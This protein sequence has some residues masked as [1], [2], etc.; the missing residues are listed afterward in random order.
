MRN[1][2][3]TNITLPALTPVAGAHYSTTPCIPSTISLNTIHPLAKSLALSDYLAHLSTSI[4]R[5]PQNNTPPLLSSPP[6]LPA[7]FNPETISPSDMIALLHDNAAH[8]LL[9]SI[10]PIIILSGNASSCAPLIDNSQGPDNRTNRVILTISCSSD[11]P[12]P[13]SNLSIPTLLFS[14]PNL[15]PDN[16]VLKLLD[17]LPIRSLELFLLI[18]IVD[19]NPT[20]IPALTQ[21]VVPSLIALSVSAPFLGI[22]PATLADSMNDFDHLYVI[23][24]YLK[25]SVSQHV[26]AYSLVS[27]SPLPTT[28]LLSPIPSGLWPDTPPTRNQGT[29]ISNTKF[30]LSGSLDHGPFLDLSTPVKFLPLGSTTAYLLSDSQKL[31]MSNFHDYPNLNL[32]HASILSLPPPCAMLFF[33]KHILVPP[34][35][36]PTVSSSNISLLAYSSSSPH[37]LSAVESH[38]I[39]ELSDLSNSTPSP[40]PATPPLDI[41]SS[42]VT[43]TDIP[44]IQGEP[45]PTNTQDPVSLEEQ[46]KRFHSPLDSEC[47]QN[48]GPRGETRKPMSDKE[49]DDIFNKISQKSTIPTHLIPK[50]KQE[51]IYKVRELWQDHSLPSAMGT[52]C[53]IPVKKVVSV[54]PI[55]CH[56][57]AK[58]AAVKTII[59]RMLKQN[60]IQNSC[61]PFNSPAF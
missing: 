10:R 15:T 50:F 59:G 60:I 61:S 43:P 26:R 42:Y 20:S 25:P 33:L 32:T 17:L 9:S 1:I 21:I 48:Y 39:T 14:P 31:S 13:Q 36:K 22:A 56:N 7:T 24:R 58:L 35:N 54:R 47:D 30:Y 8:P 5:H 37:S 46:A 40:A 57:P 45:P 55:P 51:C 29:F 19:T 41:L 23:T 16:V 38:F 27:L 3:P 2:S 53:H 28:D 34:P 12:P 4:Y 52:E 11:P 49:V 18:S 44:L 6:P